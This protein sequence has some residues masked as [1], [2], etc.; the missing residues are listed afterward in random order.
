M[1]S[2]SSRPCVAYFEATLQKVS[3]LV[4]G[5]KNWQI[6]NN[7]MHM[8]GG[9]ESKHRHGLS[10]ANKKMREQQSVTCGDGKGKEENRVHG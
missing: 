8:S 4:T 10:S 5:E 6:D 3:S 1:R 2:E 7:V 9:L